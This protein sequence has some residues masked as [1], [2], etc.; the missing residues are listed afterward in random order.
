MKLV[1]VYSKDN[2]SQNTLM[3]F[4]LYDNIIINFTQKFQFNKMLKVGNKQLIFEYEFFNNFK[5]QFS[6]KNY[7]NVSKTFILC[8]L[9]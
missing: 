1:F 7:L 8:I 4:Y 6:L 5:K 9:I 3:F 2:S